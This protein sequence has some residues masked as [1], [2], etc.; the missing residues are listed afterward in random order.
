M[1]NPILYQT[2]IR[3]NVAL[4]EVEA[5]RFSNF[6]DNLGSAIT[7]R[8]IEDKEPH[9]W[10]ISIIHEDKPE[11]K[12]ISGA[13]ALAVG[14][15]KDD[16]TKEINPQFSIDPLP[17]TDWLGLVHEQFQPIIIGRFYI[18][19]SHIDTVTIPQDKIGIEI[20]AANAFGTGEHPTTKGCLEL[21]EKLYDDGLK[22]KNILDLG[23]GSAILSIAAAKLWPNAQIIATDMDEDSVNIANDYVRVNGI[24]AEQVIC[25]T[26]MG[27]EAEII[28]QHA[29]FDLILANILAA[30]LIN[31]AP[32]VSP[33][34]KNDGLIMLSGT[35]IEQEEDVKKAHTDQGL[36]FIDANHIDEW[37][38]FVMK[39]A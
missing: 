29:P 19:G 21:I 27:Y 37:T 39:K 33:F 15:L 9:H 17:D 22:P 38:S 26:A 1:T 4:T 8:K 30:P 24:N 32:E 5:S 18:Y 20:N 2:V 6:F 3:F 35:L 7:L 14:L 25:E 34:L 31:L 13:M 10:K 28:K 12:T 36:S 11:A 16:V 23:C